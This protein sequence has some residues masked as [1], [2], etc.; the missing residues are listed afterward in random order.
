MLAQLLPREVDNRFQGSTLSIWLL[1][2]I[3]LAILGVAGIHVFLPDSGGQAVGT[4]PLDSF[5]VGGANTVV[6]FIGQW[7]LL[8]GMWALL[9]VLVLLRYRALIPL[10]YVSVLLGY[11]GKMVLGQF[12][13]V[14]T[15]ET[16]P[17]FY[18]N[19][20]ILLCAIV[21]FALA[22]RWSGEARA[23]TQGG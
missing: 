5:T 9:Y 17:G 11:V 22:V 4:I 12:K 20:G 14:L 8:Q 1:Y 19:V 18:I 6:A 7:G 10:M 3:S 15:V 13:P 21:G 16:P 23:A 2:A